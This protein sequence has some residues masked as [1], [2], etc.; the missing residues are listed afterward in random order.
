MPVC[1]SHTARGKAAFLV[2]SAHIFFYGLDFKMMHGLVSGS[3]STPA[4][5]LLLAFSWESDSFFCW[6]GHSEGCSLSLCNPP[7]LIDLVLCMSVS[8]MVARKPE[9][10]GE[11]CRSRC[12]LIAQLIQGYYWN[13]KMWSLQQHQNI[14]TGSGGDTNSLCV[15][16][17]S[18]GSIFLS[19]HNA[20]VMRT[21]T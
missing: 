7:L 21:Q 20:L 3:L 9:L 11:W 14:C 10:E 17:Y 8:R 12:C 13:T 15:V 5:K 19:N 6:A 16:W 1:S 2:N 4:T 18:M